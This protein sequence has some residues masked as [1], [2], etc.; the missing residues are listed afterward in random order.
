[1]NALAFAPNTPMSDHTALNFVAAT[2]FF[3]LV[4]TLIVARGVFRARRRAGAERPVSRALPIDGRRTALD[5]TLDEAFASRPLDNTPESAALLLTKGGE[6]FAARALS[7]AAAGRSLD[8]M[9]Y[10]WRGDA[11]GML[12]ASELWRAAERGVRVR[13]LVDDVNA[14]GADAGLAALDRHE[15]IEVRIHNPFFVRAGAARLAELLLRFARMNHRMHNK[16]WIADGRLA[17]VGGR[18]IEDRYFDA[19]EELN[20]RDL[21]MVVMGPAVSDA[22][23]I[24]D[25]YWNHETAWPIS[26]LVEDDDVAMDEALSEILAARESPLARNYARSA[27]KTPDLSSFLASRGPV[28][29]SSK[30]EIASDPPGKWREARDR[31]EW[32]V[33]R[34]NNWLRGARSEVLIVSPYFVPRRRFTGALR[35]LARKRVDVA[36]V[37]NSLSANDVA[38]VH[39]GYMRYRRSLLRG[40]V[41][42]H[43]VRHANDHDDARSVF[44]SSNASL[45]TKAALFDRA[46]GFVGSFNMDPRSARVNTEMGVFFEDET[47]A[48]DLREEIERLRNPALSYRVALEGL[49]LRWFDDATDPPVI[50]ED[51]PN[52]TFTQRMTARL[53]GWLPIEQ[54]L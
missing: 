12:L 47:L 21:D 3:G 11:L 1:M 41:A 7:A 45:H 36:V 28:R 37:T 4:L 38:A 24:F 19:S 51:E 20:F 10:A 9:Y 53:A 26:A 50:Y 39:G 17:V 13:L 2:L 40:E 31:R 42:L 32:I 44:G 14:E 27:E 34:L 35:A 48:A 33:T 43:E 30:I 52:S 5:K 46:R 18:N 23:R 54:E 16:A 22:E 15:N 25:S 6:A 49:R 29:W 8:L